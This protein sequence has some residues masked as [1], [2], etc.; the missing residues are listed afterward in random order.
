VGNVSGDYRPDLKRRRRQCLK[1]AGGK[2]N[3]EE[4]QEILAIQ[5]RRCIYCNL[6]FTK[7]VPATKDHLLAVRNGGADWDLNLVMACRSCNSRR[8]DIPFRTFCRLLS[9]T[10]NRRILLHLSSRILA[11]DLNR[12]SVEVFESFESGLAAHDPRHWRYCDIQRRYASA[13]RNAA[14]NQLLPRSM[15]TILL[16]RIKQLE[17][18][19]RQR[20]GIKKRKRP[21]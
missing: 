17:S 4:I 16:K 9:P 10:Q 3:N 21:I 19:T 13:R 14:Q 8:C 11:L 5:Q 15:G 6:R 18:E 20:R 2:H 1:A 7:K 12:L